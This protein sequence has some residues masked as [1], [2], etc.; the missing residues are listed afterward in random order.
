MFELKHFSDVVVMRVSGVLNLHNVRQ[1]DRVLNN[2]L[3]EEISRVVLDLSHLEH[4]DYKLVAHL[5]DRI[6]EIQCLGGEI[7]LASGNDYVS[8]ILK[9]MGFEEELYL[10]VEDAVISFSPMTEEKWQ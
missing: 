9:A 4:I 7:K 2:A 6:I 1:F 3:E 10:T 5:V 8:N